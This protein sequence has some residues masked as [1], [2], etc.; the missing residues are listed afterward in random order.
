MD[1]LQEEGKAPL[2]EQQGN[3][4]AQQIKGVPPVAARARLLL[5]VR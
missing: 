5:C 3:Q 1:I 2:T 4:L